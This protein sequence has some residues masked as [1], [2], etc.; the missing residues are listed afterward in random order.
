[1]F[2][3]VTV[4]ALA[5]VLFAAPVAHADYIPG[6]SL[7]VDLGTGPT[8]WT[9]TGTSDGYGSFTYCSAGSPGCVGGDATFVVGGVEVDWDFLFNPDPVVSGNFSVKNTNPTPQTFTLTVTVPVAVSA[10]WVMGGSTVQQV[11]DNNGNGATMGTLA[12]SAFYR[13]MINGGFVSPPN[14]LGNLFPHDSS[15][16]VGNFLSGSDGGAAFGT[17]IP[18]AAGNPVAVTSM[19]IQFQFTLT[20]GDSASTQGVFVIEPVPEPGSMLLLG[21]GL[22]GLGLI[23]RRK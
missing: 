1:M 23:R 22:A 8:V 3:S 13:A 11:T 16:S 21:M 15:F 10:P 7:S 20:P 4:L 9:P 6:M 5:L 2:R 12:G 18:S 19:G 14:L 17:P